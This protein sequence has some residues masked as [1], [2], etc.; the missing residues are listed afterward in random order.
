MSKQ[1]KKRL[2]RIISNA[3]DDAKTYNQNDVGLEA[4]LLHIII[5]KK[6]RA[7]G[8][9][10]RMDVDM[11]LL[12][13][14]L[15]SVSYDKNAASVISTTIKK[16]PF[17]NEVKEV[18]DYASYECDAIND[19]EL[20]TCHIMLSILKLNK[21]KLNKILNNFKI[22]Y[23]TFKETTQMIG[24]SNDNFDDDID[25]SESKKPQAKKP[26]K[27][28]TP[29]LNSFCV[30][31]TSSAEKGEL[32]PVIGRDAEIK[33]MSQILAR[34]KKQNPVL[35]G[36]PGVGKSAIVEGLAQMIADGKA[37]RVL[38]NKRIYSMSLTSL[39]SG[40][41]YRGQFEERMKSLME[42]LK[43][44]RNI[45]LFIDEL[46]TVVG[47]GNS[48]GGLDVA[49][50]FKPPLANGEIQ[51]IGAT[52]L[53]EYRENIEKDGAL[54]RRFQS[55][56]VPEPSVAETITILKNIRTKY[57]TH[58]K[59]RYTDEALEECVKMSD[60][61]IN[62]RFMPDKAIDIMDEAGASAN[63]SQ[64]KPNTL[65]VLELE[66]K[67]IT[68]QKFEV[69]NKQKYEE[70]AELRDK[71][72]K[73]NDRIVEETKKWERQ[74]DEKKTV[75]DVDAICKTISMMTGIPLNKMS[76]QENKRLANLD[77][78]IKQYIIGQ[79]EAID[80]VTQ[81]I[82]RNRLGIKPK[83]KPQGAFFCLGISGSGKTELA[84]QLAAQLF[85][86]QDSLIRLDMSEYTEKHSVSK[87]IGAPPGYIGYEQ[88]GQLTEKV[89]RK[90]YSVVLFDEIEKAHP[91]IFN[92]LLQLLDEGH[93]TDSLGRKVDFKNCM[94]IL[95]SNVGVKDLSVA[96]VG[97]KTESH[98]ANEE[99]RTR[100]I[101]QKALNKKFSPE[102]LNR[103]DEVI[104]FNK[105]TKENINKIILIEVDKLKERISEVGYNIILSDDCLDFL[106]KEGY[107]DTFGARPLGR[108]I[109]LYVGNL[110][111]D[112]ILNG[113]I[114]EGDDINIVYDEESNKLIVK[115]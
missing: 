91:E 60:R 71:E 66:K 25:D 113:R 54:T 96:S 42:E 46:H 100:S 67:S 34:R 51:I 47:T 105:L 111:A 18:I 63:I 37:P 114:K 11:T 74:L 62:D 35:L 40:T 7:C 27:S 29:A 107:S 80:K 49:N 26:G 24:N 101:I 90:P 86:D 8:I 2:K 10:N 13:D 75:I 1:P 70:A 78:V 85:G 19:A 98:V 14:T 32:D 53:H 33:R 93:L 79:D 69:V 94:I 16:I 3:V 38:S 110:I 84:K 95:T 99:E 112:E 43:E 20:D 56:M 36:D 109:Q 64:E 45:I 4:I 50:I 68:E 65:K 82:K 52:T 21:F 57:E 12:E 115:R 5:D 87:L 15:R 104:I 92:T 89:R 58:H 48:S 28:N 44:N 30:D 55:V 76:S 41:K 39:I 9:L 73:I 106:A 22:K 88:G 6:N 102:F 72:T 103:I 17:S 61:Y 108:A 97:F 83:N 81:A 23:D 31:I 59:V 77:K